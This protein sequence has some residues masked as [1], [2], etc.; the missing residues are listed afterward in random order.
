MSEKRSLHNLARLY[1][2]QLDYYDIFGRHIEP[3]AD[4]V[5]Q[6]LRILGAPVE[7][8]SD[9]SDALRQR[10][11]SLW[12]RG[13][14]PVVVTW[15]RKP[16]SLKLRL[17]RQLSDATAKY[18]VVL[19]SGEICEGKCQDDV[20]AKRSVTRVE[21]IDYTT[22]RL[23]V[24]EKLPLGYHRLSLQ[25]K[26]LLLEAYLFSAPLENPVRIGAPTRPWGIFCPVYALWSG[27][28]WRPGDFSDLEALVDFTD[29]MGGDIVG[30][31][32]LLSAFLDEPFN[33]S[34]YSPV[35]RLFWNEF[36]LDITRIP[37]L[38]GC[39]AAR[40]TIESS[41]FQSEIT[42]LKA[43]PLIDYRRIMTQKRRILEELA[44]FLWSQ[45]SERRASFERFVA[46]HPRAEDYAAFR[47]KV[48]QERKPWNQ[49]P[50]PSR[51]GTLR[52]GD[53]S[54]PAKRFHLYVQW[55]ADEQVRA[56]WEKTKAGGPALYLD[57]PLGVNRD[58]YDVWRE[59]AVFALEANG[60]APP[61]GFFTK[62]QNWGFPP[63]HPEGLRQQGYRYY[64]HCLRHH[65]QYAGM[66]RIDHVM[67]LHRFYWVPEGFAPHEGVYVRYPAEEFYAVLN[68]E[69]HRH[70]ARVVG[71]NLGT[72]PP[73]VNRAL[74]RHKILGMYVS[75]F[76][77]T[78]DAGHALEE[79]P[80]EAVVSLNTHDTPTFAGFWNEKD[81]ED[82]KNLGLLTEDGVA[83]EK[84][85]R[86]R[87]REALVTYLRSH[88]CL[89]D[90]AAEPMAVLR[91][92]L[93]YLAR[94]PVRLLLVN[95][96]DLWLEPMPQNVPGTW[97]ERPNW[98]RKARFPLETLREMAS[99]VDTLKMI[100]N[101]R[102]GGR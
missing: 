26:D 40:A 61:D 36:F 81:I 82:R 92:W 3:P 78:Q 6:V 25:L 37:D 22:R 46:S 60:G 63:L 32:P 87:Q 9:L 15:D 50:L 55:Q 70:Q 53:Y 29:R 13:M 8:M 67:G 95:L 99:V 72:V 54:E 30:T 41:A 64:I 74:A 20:T 97:Q 45:P 2:V 89:D 71:E 80:P 96:E 62:G 42:S 85:H 49:W 51:N 73:A 52:S 1:D 98:Q 59:R 100:R 84:Q 58:G 69:S 76:G 79:A 91:A 21:G 83:A 94:G 24:N 34:P 35:S 57:F 56:L 10:R 47:A 102:K 75:Q 43:A 77:V 65:L 11:Q 7:R 23:T 101:I 19:E 31:L 33:P 48:E 88:G 14:D 90:D 86:A 38:Q 93:S 5:L 16:L 27:K 4:A 18:Q 28:S 44:R 12:Q 17:P 68:L 39:P 66:L